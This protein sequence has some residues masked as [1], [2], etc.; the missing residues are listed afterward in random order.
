MNMSVE[1][2]SPEA[3]SRPW[4]VY[5]SY[6]AKCFLVSFVMVIFLMAMY[7]LTRID[8]VIPPEIGPGILFFSAVYVA[9]SYACL[10]SY[11]MRHHLRRKSGSPLAGKA[12]TYNAVLKISNTVRHLSIAAVVAL[13]LIAFT[14][15]LFLPSYYSIF[16]GRPVYVH[17]GLKI[18][19][20]LV[21]SVILIYLTGMFVLHRR[22]ID[23]H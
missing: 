23:S 5:L 21:A 13:V 4:I 18:L 11:E 20:I 9:S 16:D 19:A 3:E 12:E 7:L 22:L 10:I 15:G 2:V 14:E 8:T 1:A 17:N 6:S